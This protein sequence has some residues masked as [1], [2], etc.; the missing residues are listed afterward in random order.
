VLE[1]SRCQCAGAT[2]ETAGLVRGFKLS[3]GLEF[4]FTAGSPKNEILTPRRGWGKDFV[5]PGVLL[6]T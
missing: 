4:A 5:F 1:C 2:G 6:I 3:F